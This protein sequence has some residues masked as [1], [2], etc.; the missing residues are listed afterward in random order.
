[1]LMIHNVTDRF[2]KRFQKTE[3]LSLKFIPSKVGDVSMWSKK[4][5][6]EY[7]TLITKQ[8][9]YAINQ[10]YKPKPG[11]IKSEERPVLEESSGRRDGGHNG[12]GKRLR[13]RPDD[14]RDDRSKKDV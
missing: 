7:R 6:E 14:K 9:E 2:Y 4:T 3:S 1:M 8:E 10:A 11:A 13:D 12:S 5:E